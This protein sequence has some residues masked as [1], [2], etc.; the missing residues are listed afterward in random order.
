MTTS[1]YLSLLHDF[2]RWN[3]GFQSPGYKSIGNSNMPSSEFIQMLVEFTEFDYS[4]LTE[5]DYLEFYATHG[6]CL[7]LARDLRG[8]EYFDH[9][10]LSMV[11]KA[12]AQGAIEFLLKSVTD[13]IKDA[14]PK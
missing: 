6:P 7:H 9:A 12:N 13:R 11:A 3:L 2:T 10:H 4:K 14:R 5:R 8:I 1:K